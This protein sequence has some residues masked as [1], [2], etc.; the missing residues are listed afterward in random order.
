MKILIGL[1]KLMI[2]IREHIRFENQHAVLCILTGFEQWSCTWAE[3]K[4]EPSVNL[5]IYV[6]IS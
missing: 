1:E 5:F 2:N 4:L 6:L 3:D